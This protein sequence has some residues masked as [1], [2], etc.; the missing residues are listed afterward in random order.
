[1]AAKIANIIPKFRLNIQYAIWDH[2]KL[3]DQYDLR[4]TSN[5]AKF[6]SRFVSNPMSNGSLSILKTFADLINV[7]PSVSLFLKV[8]FK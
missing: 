6:C 1:V 4:Q 3:I 5:L 7:S 2:I 8:F